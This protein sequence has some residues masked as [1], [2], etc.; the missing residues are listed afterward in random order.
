MS[1]IIIG[2]VYRPPAGDTREFINFMETILSRIHHERKETYIMGDFNLDIT[3]SVAH[4]DALEFLDLMH[5]SSLFPLIDK[6]TRVTPNSSTLLDNIFSNGPSGT[7]K[8]D[9]R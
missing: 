1:N 7:L 2:V 6:P 8:S 3:G 5:T 4:P 9:V